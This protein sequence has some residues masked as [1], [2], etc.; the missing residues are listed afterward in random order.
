MEELQRFQKVLLARVSAS[1][2]FFGAFIVL[3]VASITTADEALQVWVLA[4][5]LI[6]ILIMPRQSLPT[7]MRRPPEDADAATLWAKLARMRLWLSSVRVVYLLTA[8]FLLL[9]LPELL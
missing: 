9:V 5:A 8:V 1:V 7:S 6:A 3:A 4:P 2:A